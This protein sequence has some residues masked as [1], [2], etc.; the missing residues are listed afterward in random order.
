M[1]ITFNKSFEHA[2]L[3]KHKVVTR[4]PV[5]CEY[6]DYGYENYIV[7]LCVIDNNQERRLCKAKIVSV[8]Q[9]PLHNTI[10]CK[11]ELEKE[12]VKSIQEFA[13]IWDSFYED[14]KFETNP[15][16]WVISFDIDC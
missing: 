11:N 1:K 10:M 6:C 7:E 15:N 8:K 13:R 12:G 4:R 16:V 14:Y 3:S 2:I 5:K 9:E